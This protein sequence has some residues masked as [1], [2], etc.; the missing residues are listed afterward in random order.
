M[1]QYGDEE[2]VTIDTY[3]YDQPTTNLRRNPYIIP[4]DKQ[5]PLNVI[6]LSDLLEGGEP[7][8][9]FVYSG[10]NELG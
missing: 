9:G 1:D 6:S 5:N 7:F 2:A 8:N 3:F 4:S 10:E